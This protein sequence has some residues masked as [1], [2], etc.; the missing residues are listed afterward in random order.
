MCVCAHLAISS[1]NDIYQLSLYGWLSVYV[2]TH[3]WP[4]NTHKNEYIRPKL[5]ERWFNYLKC[6]HHHHY[7]YCSLF[8]FFFLKFSILFSFDMIEFIKNSIVVFIL[9]ILIS[10]RSDWWSNDFFFFKKK[11]QN[12]DKMCFRFFFGFFFR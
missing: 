7:Y 3:S 6:F 10:H 9:K 4:A 11:K 5:I 12:D 1:K 8:F 2:R